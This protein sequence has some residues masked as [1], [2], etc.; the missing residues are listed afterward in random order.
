MRKK[1]LAG[2]M[3]V[4]CC[5]LLYTGTAMAEGEKLGPG[6]S[7]TGEV[8]PP[9]SGALEAETQ[10][11]GPGVTGGTEGTGVPSGPAVGDEF[12]Q[13]EPLEPIV[14]ILDKYS[15][16]QMMGDISALMNKYGT[17]RI[18]ANKIGTSLDGRDLYEVVVG[19][20]AAEKHVLIQA[21]IHA[22]E[23]MTPL[24]VM[25]QIEYA[26][27]YYDRATYHGRNLSDMFNQVALHFVPMVN[28]DG[29]SI[30]QFGLEGL[31]SEELRQ[32]VLTCYNSDLASGRTSSALDG[33]LMRWKAN[34]RGVDLNRNF[35]A[36]WG[37][38]VD[39]NTNPSASGFKGPAPLSEPESTALAN[40]GLSRTWSATISYHSMGQVI[41]W[42]GESN[43]VVD[44]SNQ[45]A[46]LAASL[47][48]YQVISE[49][50]RGGFKDWMQSKEG[51]VC[52][53][54]IEV[55]TGACPLPVSQFPTVWA[56]NKAVW[57][58]TMEYVLNS[59]L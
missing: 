54:T 14:P 7:D 52:G 48:G 1:L 15:Y 20:P 30:S 10:P 47:T 42:N 53:I 49:N 46:R 3:A 27:D 8:L 58:Q 17:R 40:L 16:D 39:S 45:L 55:G 9:A 50:G 19:N 5:S 33:Y 56:Q 11:A 36:S 6:Y 35:D 59:G 2:M 31:K 37:A 4:M 23:Y 18:Q 43:R 57:L 24:L 12:L 22:R 28:P 32:G 34:A 44:T 21:G 13:M 51:P 29:I 41:Y 38:I 26:L 25:K